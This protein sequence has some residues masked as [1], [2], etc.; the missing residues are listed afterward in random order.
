MLCGAVFLDEGFLRLLKSKMPRGIRDKIGA[1]DIQWI[2]SQFWE[3]GM[4]PQFH[5]DNEPFI[6]P[7]PYGSKTENP[8]QPP[9]L[10][11]DRSALIP[12]NSPKQS[13][14]D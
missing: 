2:M 6:V 10:E 8:F 7:V 11:F 5:G 3:N 9:A 1:S 12:G 13:F 4:K 14:L